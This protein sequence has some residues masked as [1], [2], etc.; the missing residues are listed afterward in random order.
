MNATVNLRDAILQLGPLTVGLA[1]RDAG[2]TPE[3]CDYWFTVPGFSIRRSQETQETLLH[4]L[5]GLIQ[6][7]RGEE[8]VI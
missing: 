6:V 5:R 7:I 4:V 1:G 3:F 2:R 8:E